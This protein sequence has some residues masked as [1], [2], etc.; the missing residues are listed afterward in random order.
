MVVNAKSAYEEFKAKAEALE[1]RTCAFIDGAYR[2]SA[3]GA[4]FATENP[5]TGRVITE[6]AACDSADVDEAVRS[7]RRAYEQGA[8][9]RCSPSERKDKLLRFADLIE[10]YAVELA[11]LD[12]LEAGKPITDCTGIDVPETLTCIRWYA[13]AA[14][15]LYDQ[16]APTAADK[17]GLILREPVGVVGAVVPWNFPL[18]MAAWKIGPA[19]AAGNSV[20]LKPAELSSLRDRKSVV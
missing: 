8:W 14:D 9:S 17:L 5:A 18:L 7:A 3:S 10:K 12:A 20:I 15:K 1:F 13:E 11:L 2:D 6:I 16:V 19:L 4:T